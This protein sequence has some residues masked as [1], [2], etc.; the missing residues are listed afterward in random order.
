[1]TL[2]DPNIQLDEM[3]SS[4]RPVSKWLANPGTGMRQI[5]AY[6]EEDS[7][8]ARNYNYINE[9]ISSQ[10]LS[11][12]MAQA[13]TRLLHGIQTTEIKTR[14]GE[15]VYRRLARLESGI[16][17]EG[18]EPYPDSVTIDLARRLVGT[19]FDADTPTPSVVPGEAGEVVFVWHKGG[20]DVEIEVS[21]NETT[22]W[23]Y[24]QQ[25]GPPVY[26][27]LA[28]KLPLVNSVLEYLASL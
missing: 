27:P 7:I 8:S 13:I 22:F 16:D 14:W 17:K 5:W 24:A 19:L 4:A 28:E 26:G 9:G 6:P 21:P 2:T 10:L 18:D 1:M 25:Q 11:V 3:W 15:Y 12:P 23:C 20:L